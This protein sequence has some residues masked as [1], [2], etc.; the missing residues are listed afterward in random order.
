[1]QRRGGGKMIGGTEKRTRITN[2]YKGHEWPRRWDVELD[3]VNFVAKKQ[4][5]VVVVIFP[6]L[7][8][9]LCWCHTG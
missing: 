3:L 1:M 6:C 8:N 7:C 5:L 2:A 9:G 4:V